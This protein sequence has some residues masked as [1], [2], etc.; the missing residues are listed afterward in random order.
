MAIVVSVLCSAANAHE[1]WVEPA[2]YTPAAGSAV[3]VELHHGE[4]FRGEC[5]PRRADLIE[6]FIMIGP[7]GESP[8]VG[9]SGAA[10]SYA[11][12]TRPGLHVIAYHSRRMTNRL[13]ADAFERYLHEEG[14]DQI[15][16]LRAE[17]GESARAGREV[18]SR[19]AKA[20]IAGDGDSGAGAGAGAAA[21]TILGLPIE[22]TLETNPGT[23][24]TDDPLVARVWFQGRPVAG[25]TVV[26]V[27]AEAPEKLLRGETDGEGRVQFTLPARGPWM[28]TTIQMVPA[29]PDI[30]ADWESFWASL[31]FAW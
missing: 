31:T 26:A 14:L 1:F 8:V 29:P 22:I 28:L 4:R 5:V 16:V 15:S 18:Y 7:D 20:L 3:R 25:V 17:R 10:A 6:R 24:E 19:C 13:D 23:L 27:S 9:R 30:D 21:D 12:V 11:R 2:S